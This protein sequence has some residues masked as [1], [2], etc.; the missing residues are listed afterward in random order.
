MIV[1][2]WDVGKIRTAIV[3]EFVDLVGKKVSWRLDEKW[4]VHPS[5][6]RGTLLAGRAGSGDESFT[7]Y[8]S[9]TA[10]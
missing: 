6:K 3:S 9:N 2:F 1:E 7:F 8:P 5:A 10:S 4:L